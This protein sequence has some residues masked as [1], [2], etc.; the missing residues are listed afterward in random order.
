MPCYE[1]IE[2]FLS[3]VLHPRSDRSTFKNFLICFFTLHLNYLNLLK[4]LGLYLIYLPIP[5]LIIDKGNEVETTPLLAHH[6][7]YTHQ[8]CTRI[9]ISVVLF[10]LSHK[11]SLII[12][13]QRDDTQTR[14]D[15][16]VNEPKTPYFF[17]LL[18]ISS[19]IWLSLRVHIYFKLFSILDLSYP[20]VF[21]DCSIKIIYASP[22]KR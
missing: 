19:P 18:I 9:S 10:F 1:I 14:F 22:C 17:S 13:F 20:M 3:L 4:I 15:S 5:W 16:I 12:F 21:T 8:M 7:G 11:S 6:M 2:K